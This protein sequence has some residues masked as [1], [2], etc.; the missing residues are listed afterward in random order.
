VLIWSNSGTVLNVIGQG[1]SYPFGLAITS[2]S[3]IVVGSA[4]EPGA[5]VLLNAT[6]GATSSFGDPIL[7]NDYEPLGMTISPD[8]RVFVA[9]VNLGI[10][11]FNLSTG[12]VLGTISAPAEDI[13]S[14]GLAYTT[15]GNGLLYAVDVFNDRIVTFPVGCGGGCG[16]GPG[17]PSS[18]SFR[19][20]STHSGLMAVI[21]S[22]VVLA[23]SMML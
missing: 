23:L 3:V 2:S 7:G 12:A 9:S 13:A 14:Y 17:T 1:I 19:T 8:G 16:S 4:N 22:M 10:Y 11:V 20:I 21:I 5:I 15:S 18:G 6:T